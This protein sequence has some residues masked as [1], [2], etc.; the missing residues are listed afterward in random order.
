MRRTPAPSS[1]GVVIAR[2]RPPACRV[3]TSARRPC[4]RPLGC[5][6]VAPVGSVRIATRP[7]GVSLPPDLTPLLT[8]S[9]R[10]STKGVD[11]DR[12]SPATFGAPSDGLN[13]YTGEF[14]PRSLPGAPC[15][16][17]TRTLGR[18]SNPETPRSD[19]L[20]YGHQPL[21]EIPA[22]R[23]LPA[24]AACSS[25]LE[26]DVAVPDHRPA[27]FDAATIA[28]TSSQVAAPARL[29][30]CHRRSASVRL[31]FPRNPMVRARSIEPGGIRLHE[32]RAPAP[33]GRLEARAL[34][35]PSQ[36]HRPPVDVREAAAYVGVL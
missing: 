25:H 22:C 18:S 9:D 4:P 34:T 1:G 19:A 17:G 11:E 21:G 33:K 29:P 7:T 26:M 3:D 16:Q 35:V 36:D 32:P 27:E 20:S 28:R 30:V 24:S 6:R 10:R 2:K 23:G 8:A 31:A 15:T 12:K 13:D 5:I 14:D